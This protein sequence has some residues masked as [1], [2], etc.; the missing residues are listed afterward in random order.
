MS[1]YYKIWLIKS[2]L[3]ITGWHTKNIL[4]DSYVSNFILNHLDAP[5]QPPRKPPAAPPNQNEELYE[6]VTTVGGSSK[7]NVKFKITFTSADQAVQKKIFQAPSDI[8]W[9]YLQEKLQSMFSLQRSKT[10]AFFQLSFAYCKSCVK[11]RLLWQLSMCRNDELSWTM[12]W[13]A[14]LL[15]DYLSATR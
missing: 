9:P 15:T 12:S 1:K 6:V 5:A 8:S 4:N 13:V 2:N 14:C 3:Q 11:P 10:C 7:A